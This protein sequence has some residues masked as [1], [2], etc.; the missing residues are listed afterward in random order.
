M[1]KQ[2]LF[3]MFGL[4]LLTLNLVMPVTFAAVNPSEQPDAGLSL[5]VSPSPLV[6]S[7]KPGERKTVEIKIYNAGLTT[8][9]LKIALQAFKVNR[10]NSQVTLQ[11]NSPVEVASWVSFA[12]P[13]FSVK[14]GE[15]F[16]ER[17][18]IDTPA[19]A[20][21]NYNFAL[22]VSRQIPS[23]AAQG[24]S[25]IQGSVAIFTLLNIDRP[26]ASRKLVVDSIKTDRR[27]YEYLP[28]EITVK[29]RNDGNTL[30]LP[31]GNAYIQRKS[32]SIKPISVLALNPGSLYLLPGVQ[33]EYQVKWT[34][35]LPAYVTTQEA[36]NTPPQQ[37][38]SWN[39][40]DSHFRIG[41]YVARFIVVY[42][43]G[44]RDVPVEAETN[45]W[46]FPWKLI[47]GALVGVVVLV[48]GL[49]A[50]V[51]FVYRVL[52]RNHSKYRA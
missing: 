51:R 14:P 7:T 19:S 42:D 36:A 24:Q 5:Q 34:D 16:T 35:G 17:V 11:P 46:V 12:N 39:W 41:R 49:G 8:E 48:I 22:I 31:G 43:D 20:G 52:K 45:F 28:A 18:L 38:L 2:K 29:L 3:G 26:G 47:L 33:R 37:N 23:K 32:D 13:N 4:A 44:K 50:M 27:V 1:L 6:V 10:Y 21:F 15:R 40:R 25:A 9:N 30:L